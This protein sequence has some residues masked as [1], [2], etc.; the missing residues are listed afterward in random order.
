M[1]RSQA[2]LIERALRELRVLE[3]GESP[4]ASEEQET[5]DAVGPLF[6]WLRFHNVYVVHNP[7]QIE[8]SAF[9]PLAMLLAEE[10][11]FLVGRSADEAM[12]RKYRNQLRRIQKQPLARN[13]M[14]VDRALQRPYRE[15]FDGSR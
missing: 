4:S 2:Q 7:A 8:D 12:Q 13:E 3:E 15:Q 10:V 1:A 14:H 6:E 5:S 9:V 11:S